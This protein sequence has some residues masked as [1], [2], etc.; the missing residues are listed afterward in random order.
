MRCFWWPISRPT[1][2]SWDVYPIYVIASCI[3]I[4]SAAVHSV[5]ASVFGLRTPCIQDVAFPWKYADDFPLPRT[6]DIQLVKNL[7]RFGHDDKVLNSH[8]CRLIETLLVAPAAS[9]HNFSESTHNPS[10]FIGDHTCI[11]IGRD[12]GPPTLQHEFTQLRRPAVSK[13]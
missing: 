6:A 3:S 1:L 5:Q 7:F 13:K 8:S 12:C 11:A 2:T 9:V 4:R 10:D